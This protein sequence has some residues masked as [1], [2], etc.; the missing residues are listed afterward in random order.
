MLL[1]FYLLLF[2]YLFFSP[3]GD[4]PLIL[5]TKQNMIEFVKLLLKGGADV[6]RKDKVCTM[7]K[8]HTIWMSELSF[9][10]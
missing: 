10:L 7:L 4:T 3:Q 8:K 6:S 1:R 2:I 5:A 9:A